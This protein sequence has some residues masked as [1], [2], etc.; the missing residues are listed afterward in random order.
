VSLMSPVTEVV[1][2]RANKDIAGNNFEVFVGFELTDQQLEFNR[3]GKR[4]R[5]DSGVPR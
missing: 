4:F 1:I 3:D 5:I 2:P